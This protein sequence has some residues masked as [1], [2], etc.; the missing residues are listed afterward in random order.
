MKI[1][2]GERRHSANNKPTVAQEIRNN[3]NGIM[4]FSDPL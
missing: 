3:S 4:K 2:Y 1:I